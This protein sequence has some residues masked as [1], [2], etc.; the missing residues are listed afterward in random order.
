MLSEIQIVGGINKQVTPTGAEGKWIDC[1]N[2]RFRYGYPEKIGGWEQS[3]ASTLV[4]VARDMHIWSDL[5]GKRY[6]AIGTNKGLFIYHDGQMYDVSPLDTNITSCTLTTTNNSATV[7]VNKAGHGLELGDLFLFS[8]VT[9]PLSGTGFV[10]AD[11]TQNVFEVITRTSDSFTVTAGKVESGAGFTAGGSVTLSPYFKVGDAVQVT[12]YGYGTGLYGGTNPSITSTTL[13]GALLNDTNGTGGSGTTITLTSVT[14][15][16]GTGGTMLVGEEL[17][18]YTGVAGSTVTGITRGASGSVRSGHSDGAVVQEASSFIGW[19]DAS[20]TGEVTLEPGNWSLDNFGQILVATVKN[21]KT[22]QWNPSSDSALSTRATVISNAPIQSVM[23]VVSDRDR[24]LI[25]LGTETTIGTNSQDKMFIRFADQENFEDYTPTSTNT[26]GTFRIDSGTKIVGAVNAGSYILIL[27]DTSAYTMQFVGPP[28]TFGIQQVGANCGLIS[29][30]A[31]VAVNGVV[32]WMGRAG[33]FYIYDGTVKKIDC[34]V[35][36]FVFTTQDTDDLGINF[37]AADVVYAGYNSLFSEINW[38]YPKAGSSQIDRVVTLN[39]KEGLW[40]IGSLSRTTYYD[41]TIFDNPY[42]TEYNTTT[43]PNFPII[44]GVTNTNGATTLYAH[45]KG[46]NQ[47][48]ADGTETAI[49]GSIQ[50]GDFEVK[51]QG[52]GVVAT[53]E[54]FMKI[55]RFVPDFRA[56]DGNA[57]VTLNLKDFPSDTEASSSLGPFTVSS[58]TQKV[59]TRARARAINLKIENVTTNESWRYGTFKADVQQDGRR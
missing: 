42:A 13:N 19:G 15:F 56:L 11:F 47:V 40:T 28:F 29:Q 30:H 5:T 49:I 20:P 6:I 46:T 45:E 54:F 57:K 44:Q 32:Y 38:F 31:I 7:T 17:I 1:D 12:G 34:Q 27:T 50:S 52:D 10:G 37:D 9:L 18:T 23:T 26:A 33:G 3:T 58:S 51:A 53:G 25:H 8:S 14:G 55:R 4:G 43:V 41:K 48:T 2:V 36:D 39:Y 22:F 24:H 35:E 21:N 59:D 16:S